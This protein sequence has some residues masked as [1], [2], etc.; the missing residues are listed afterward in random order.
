MPSFPPQFTHLNA[1]MCCAN[2]GKEEDEPFKLKMC[3]ACRSVCYCTIHCQKSH[4]KNHKQQCNL[5]VQIV[6]VEEEGFLAFGEEV[7]A[8]GGEGGFV[9]DDS[10]GSFGEGAV[11]AAVVVGAKGVGLE[12]CVYHPVVFIMIIVKLCR[13]SIRGGIV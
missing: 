9:V 8:G 1:L 3:T 6:G 5:D 11:N 10:Y 12:V 4:R 7:V 13:S 2:C